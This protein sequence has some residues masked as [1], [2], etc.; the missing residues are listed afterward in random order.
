MTAR[1][2]SLLPTD[3]GERRYFEPFLGA[4]SLFF[5]LQPKRATLSDANYQLI[6][7]YAS[8]KRAP[9]R[10]ARYLSV[11]KRAH[12]SA[13]YYAVRAQYNAGGAETVQAARFLYLN[14]AGFNGVFRVNR[15][16]AYNVPFGSKDALKLPSKDRL[17]AVAQLLRRAQLI[18]QD[19]AR[20]LR[21]A[22]DDSFYYLDPPYPPLNGTSYFTHYTLDRFSHADQRALAES[23][24]G[25]HSSGAKFMMTNAD[26]P[27]VRALYGT[28]NVTPLAVTR[29]VSCQ[30]R[31]YKVGELVITNYPRR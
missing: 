22:S 5:A 6:R 29:W 13:H 16:G 30:A 31:R 17:I 8:I 2:L 19:Y 14:A 21:L 26:T 24:H 15:Q 25:L 10:V 27:D 9:E 3:I 4:G 12:G 28:F 1:L 11:H 23:V 7:C 18:S 20:A